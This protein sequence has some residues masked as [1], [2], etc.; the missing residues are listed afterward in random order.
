MYLIKGEETEAYSGFG[1]CVHREL[2]GVIDHLHSINH[3]TLSARN[4]KPENGYMPIHLSKMF[5]SSNQKP[6]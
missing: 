5:E 2:L 4:Q 3:T 6:E 1:D